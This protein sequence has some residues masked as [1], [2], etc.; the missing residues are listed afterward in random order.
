MATLKRGSA[1]PY[2]IKSSMKSNASVYGALC[3]LLPGGV[4]S[5]VRSFRALELPPVVAARG[6]GDLLFDVEGRAYIDFCLSWGALIHGHAH[7]LLVAAAQEAVAEGSTFGLTTAAEER[8]ARRVASLFPSM[9]RMRFVSSGTEATMSAIRVARGYTGRDTIIK[10]DG[11][12]HG[13]SDALLVKPGSGAASLAA[14]RGVPACAI[15]KTLSL[16]Y[17]DAEALRAA[18]A[19]HEV[20]A[21]IVEPI[22]ANMGVVL[23]TAAF[24]EALQETQQWGALLIFD[25]VVTGFCVGRGGAQRLFDVVPDLTTLGKVVGG[26]FPAAVFGGRREVMESLAPLGAVYQAG[27][28]SGNPVAMAA[29]EASLKLLA[30]EHFYEE[31]AA[32]SAFL[33]DPIAQLIDSKGLN[34]ALQR[35]GGFFTLFFGRRRVESFA[36]AQECSLPAFRRF[37]AHMLERGVLLSPAPLEANFLCQAHTEAHL[38]H[39]REAILDFLGK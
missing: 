20:A 1:T 38:L 34:V 3:E 8:L 39:V 17:N 5:P 31:L 33:L 13:H 26:G 36:E 19:S 10:F 22:A 32:K 35:E 27:T 30:Q 18:L 15:E 28:L 9:E 2:P 11:N 37:F 6:V 4:N 7:P 23:P 24:L 16:P 12:Y 29:G 25:E 14:S 21:V